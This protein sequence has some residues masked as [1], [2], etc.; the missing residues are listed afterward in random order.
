LKD[1]VANKPESEA[2]GIEEI[3]LTGTHG[4]VRRSSLPGA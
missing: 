2:I 1:L 3:D 4:F